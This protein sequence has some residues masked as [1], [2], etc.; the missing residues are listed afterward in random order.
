MTN[1]TY[2]MLTTMTIA[3]KSSEM[4]PRMEVSVRGIPWAGLN[5]SFSA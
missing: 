2:L 4:T 3:Q 5:A 1:S